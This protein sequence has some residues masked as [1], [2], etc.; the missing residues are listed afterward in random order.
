M[1]SLLK[2]QI[3]KHLTKGLENDPNFTVFINAVDRSYNNFDDHFEMLQR[4]M[5][6]SSD[7]LFTANEQLRQ[8]TKAQKEVITKLKSVFE[9]LKFSN[10]VSENQSE[11]LEL[12]GSKLIDLID[13]KT[14]EI[15][16]VNT[17]REILL[18]QLAQQNKELNDY[19]QMISHDLKSPLRAIDAL[20]SWFIED[21]EDMLGISGI[22]S[23]DLI[24]S[25]VKKMDN[26]INGILDY[27]S[28]DI[29]QIDSYD[30]NTN[31]LVDHI[32][33]AQPL[34]SNISIVKLSVLP[35]VHGNKFR[36]KQIFQNL[37]NNAIEY[38]NKVDG[39]IEIGL[40]HDKDFW[41]FYVKDNG[42]G[43]EEKYYGKIFKTFQKLENNPESSGIGLSIVKKIVNLYG[44]KVWVES[45]INIGSTFFFTIKK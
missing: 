15:V 25:N 2:R 16:D 21:Y 14:K 38:N 22:E 31:K 27:S 11:N 7:E 26:L 3:R 17:Q 5:S 10:S 43:I 13:N 33:D 30:V 39:L 45:E 37:I 34:T 29:N 8:E 40:E 28:I 42:K 19:S 9:N 18:T 20:T 32:V 1:N 24:R 12:E 44:G 6:I 23:I 35:I 41:K 4:A 36:L